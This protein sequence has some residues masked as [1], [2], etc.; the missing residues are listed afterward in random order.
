MVRGRAVAVQHCGQGGV[1]G[2]RPRVQPRSIVPRRL[3]KPP[4]L[5]RGSAGGLG[6]VGGAARLLGGRPLLGDGGGL[7]QAL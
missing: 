4:R 3:L 1:G 2:R 6:G 7:A 5:E